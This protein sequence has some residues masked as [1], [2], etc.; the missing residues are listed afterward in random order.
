MTRATVA[1]PDHTRK[2]GVTRPP[3]SVRIEDTLL[4]M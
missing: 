2:E 3:T 1:T 4:Y